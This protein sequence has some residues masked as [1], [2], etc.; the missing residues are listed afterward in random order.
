M[1]I[2][3]QC[4]A[5]KFYRAQQ[6]TMIRIN[7]HAILLKKKIDPRTYLLLKLYNAKKNEEC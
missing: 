4:A 5:I 7:F 2:I 3:L 1:S 6:M